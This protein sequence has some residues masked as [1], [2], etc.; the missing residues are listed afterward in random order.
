MEH[1]FVTPAPPP[2]PAQK[3]D[4]I[5]CL[6]GVA[7]L[8]VVLYHADGV[9]TPGSYLPI[10][11][12]TRIFGFGH[13]GVELF[14]VLSGF[15][16]CHAHWQEPGGWIYA[17]RFIARRVTRI[18]PMVFIAATIGLS[19]R[20]LSGKPVSA[21]QILSS[22]TLLDFNFMFYPTVLWSLSLEILFYGLFVLRYIDRS[23]FL[24]L[25]AVWT[26]AAPAVYFS[27]PGLGHSLGPASTLLFHWNSLFGLGV[28]VYL[29][30][31]ARLLPLATLRLPLWTM[32]AAIFIPALIYDSY[33]IAALP[34][35]NAGLP[36][37]ILSFPYGITAALALLAVLGQKTLPQWTS[38]LAALGNASF[39][40]YLFHIFPMQLAGRAL[41]KAGFAAPWLPGVLV[42]I[43]ALSGIGIGLVAYHL[44]E[45]PL[46]R[47][48]KRVLKTG[49]AGRQTSA[50]AM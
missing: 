44:A 15:I 36:R 33:F 23:L 21:D 19:M 38:V 3:L 20:F 27:M 10:E 42:P 2:I 39:S 1:G 7:I 25:L 40:V 5:Q 41:E 29:V 30:W 6:R 18:Y 50:P 32:A 48:F 24:A 16:I 17:R 49:N 9:F 4:G 22:F 11:S 34:V 31:H 14:F 46:S 35:A 45:R 37:H 43:L 12:W 47:L 28:G 13:A 26:I 8:F